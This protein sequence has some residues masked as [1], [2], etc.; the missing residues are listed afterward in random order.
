MKIGVN[1]GMDVAVQHDIN[2]PSFR[3]NPVMIG[4][5]RRRLLGSLLAF[6]S[7]AAGTPL[8]LDRRA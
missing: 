4:R 5:R 8:L 2:D 3:A 7:E 1:S 6:G